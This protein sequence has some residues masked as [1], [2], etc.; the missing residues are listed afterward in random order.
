MEKLAEISRLLPARVAQLHRALQPGV[1]L[2][3]RCIFPCFVDHPAQRDQKTHHRLRTLH[4]RLLCHLTLD[5]KVERA[6]TGLHEGGA[7]PSLELK[8]S[9]AISAGLTLDLLEHRVAHACESCGLPAVNDAAKLTNGNAPARASTSA[10][11]EACLGDCIFVCLVGEL[12]AALGQSDDDGSLASVRVIV[13]DSPDAFCFEKLAALFEF[14]LA[15]R[16]HL[17]LIC[18]KCAFLV[19]F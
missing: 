12:L 19:D 13:L 1:R 9:A 15:R 11:D 17:S 10:T 16:L 7:L 6:A 2:A 5:H 8:T 3:E 18:L 4:P 14:F